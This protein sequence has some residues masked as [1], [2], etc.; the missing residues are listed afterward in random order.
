[1]P[2]IESKT[3]N[4][5]L[6]TASAALPLRG[7]NQTRSTQM[8]LLA[9]GKGAIEIIPRIIIEATCTTCGPLQDYS[10]ILEF[11]N[12]AC[13]H[14]RNT[15]HVVVLNGTVDIPHGK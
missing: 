11:V 12:S 5:F 9:A 1:V 8:T 15:G 10:E 13:A 7:T 6:S 3:S 2:D 14:T 4:P